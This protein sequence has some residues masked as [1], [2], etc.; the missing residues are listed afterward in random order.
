MFHIDE[1]ALAVRYISLWTEPDA[2]LRRARLEGLWAVDG[3]HVLRPP[4]EVREIA[5]GLGFEHSTFEAHGFDAI[6]TRVVRSYEK[7]VAGGAFTFRVREGAARLHGTVHFTWETLD[8]TTGAV[9][10]G[11]REVLLLD[12]DGLISVDYMFP[13]L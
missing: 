4:Q 7:F 12:A 1:Q 2:G 6:E 3:R 9:V 5:A 10:G 11:G 13:G 8:L